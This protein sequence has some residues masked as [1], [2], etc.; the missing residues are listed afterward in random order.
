MPSTLPEI[1]VR[2]V[3][4]QSLTRVKERAE[5]AGVSVAAFLL[6]CAG[7][8]YPEHG[9]AREPK[10]E[11][12]R[13]DCDACIYNFST[14]TPAVTKRGNYNLCKICA[15]EYD[16]AESN[17]AKKKS[18]ARRSTA[19]AALKQATPSEAAKTGRRG[20]RKDKGRA[21]RKSARRRR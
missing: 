18:K 20:G 4:A 15:K 11:R 7:E 9:G 3:D 17:K 10:E 2:F 8:P 16:E 21:A 6:L 19:G 14:S 13:G 5:E 1:K 12:I